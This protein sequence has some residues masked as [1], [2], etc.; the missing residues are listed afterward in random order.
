[1]RCGHH[2]PQKLARA[3]PARAHVVQRPFELKSQG[4]GHVGKMRGEKA[5]GKA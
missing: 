1:M 5:K 4:A 2:R 3:D